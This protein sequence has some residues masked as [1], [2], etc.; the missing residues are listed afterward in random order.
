[1]WKAMSATVVIGLTLTSLPEGSRQA[2]TAASRLTSPTSAPAGFER[3]AVQWLRVAG[4]DGRAMLAAVARPSGAGPFPVVILL[5][6]THGFASQYVHWAEELARAGFLSVA[7]CWFSGGAGAGVQEVSAPIPCPEVPSLQ[8]GEYPA[9]VK[10]VGA[11][12]NAA[13]SL[14]A[15]RRDRVAIIGHSR[16]GGATLQYLLANGNVQAAVLHSSGYAL[17]PAGRAAEFSV[18]LLLM[19]GTNDSPADG[20]GPNNRVELAREFE[21]SLRQHGK[22]VETSYYEGGGHNSFFTNSEQH[23]DELGRMIAFLRRRLGA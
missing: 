14:P 22:Q 5:H 13:R 17:K 11:L 19:H 15:A 3:E 23:A 16:G 6:G 12:V 4:P 8:P 20:G 9:A 18:P 1:M 21:A 7:A 2:R 10:Y